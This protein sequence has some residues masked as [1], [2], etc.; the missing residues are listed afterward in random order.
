MPGVYVREAVEEDVGR[1]AGLVA[2]LKLVN[3]E[4][5]PHFKTVPDLEKV[6]QDYV[7]EAVAS[8]KK[9]VIVAVDE[10]T[11]EIAGVLIY[12]LQDRVFYTPRI[13]AVIT[14]FYVVPR[15]RRRRIGTLLLDKAAEMAAGDGA[16]ILTVVYPAGNNIADRFYTGKGFR[17]L[18]KE[19]YRPLQ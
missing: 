2:R 7:R 10:A 16:G 17:D 13:K 8:D 19:K 11:G 3:E 6:A 4:L 14:D 9:R 12:E 15:Y 18:Q 5:D 1:V